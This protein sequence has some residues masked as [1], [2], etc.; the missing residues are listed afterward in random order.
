VLRFQRLKAAGACH[1]PGGITPRQGRCHARAEV[2]TE[3]SGGDGTKPLKT[4]IGAESLSVTT[5]IAQ[6]LGGFTRRRGDV[7]R[8]DLLVASSRRAHGAAWHEDD[9]GFN[10]A[11]LP[12]ISQRCAL[13]ALLDTQQVLELLRQRRCAQRR[14]PLDH[15]L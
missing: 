11:R 10:L 5:V 14:G 4:L 9:A 13:R 12:F 2:A 6:A 7:E 8:S 15:C 1:S 3:V